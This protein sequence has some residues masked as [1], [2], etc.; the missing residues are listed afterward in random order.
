MQSLSLGGGTF[1]SALFEQLNAMYTAPPSSTTFRPKSLIFKSPSESKDLRLFNI[2]AALK[3][4]V[5]EVSM[6]LPTEWRQRLFEKID[7]LHDPDDWEETD[8]L[9]NL[10]SFKTFLRTILQQQPMKRMSLGI[11]PDGQILAGWK[12]ERDTLSLTFLAD[13]KIRWAVVLHINDSIESAAGT[14]ALDRLQLVLQPYSPEI[15]FG[16]AD[17]LPTA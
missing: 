13:D 3:I 17:K 5:S 16:D 1:S 12:K 15:W 14:T 7:A 10:Q 6:H 4:A 11:S 2:S 8:Q 9:A